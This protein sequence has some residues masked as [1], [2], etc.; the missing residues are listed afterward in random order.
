ML[1]DAR[2]LLFFLPIFIYFGPTIGGPTIVLHRSWE[3][4]RTFGPTGGHILVLLDGNNQP[5]CVRNWLK[6]REKGIVPR[7]LRSTFR[8]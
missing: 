2:G 3:G 5:G 8:N 7:Q 1:I 6:S 4:C